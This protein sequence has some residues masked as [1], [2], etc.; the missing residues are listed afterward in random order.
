MEHLLYNI[1]NSLDSYQETLQLY[2]SLAQFRECGHTI[3]I[4]QRFNSKDPAI[5][6]LQEE[7][8]G[9]FPF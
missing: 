8:S 5:Y 6:C 1:G 4:E 9:S 3:R 7:M 2:D